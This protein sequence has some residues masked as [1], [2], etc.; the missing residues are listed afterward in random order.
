[1]K[2]LLVDNSL[3]NTGASKALI[4]TVSEIDKQE[5]EFIFLFPKGS[6]CIIAAQA[7]GFRAYEL[8]FNE[9]SKRINSLL[10][11]FPLLFGNTIK[12]KRLIKE[13]GITLVHVNDIYNMLGLSLKLQTGIKVLTHIRRMPESFPLP[14][15]KVW[16]RLHV[17]YADHIIAVSQANKA[18]L[19]AN[20]KTTV[21]YDPLPQ[22]EQYG[23]YIAKKQLNKQAAILYLANFTDGKGHL[24]ALKLVS[25]FIKE[26]PDWQLS[27]HLYGGNF[28]LEKNASYKQSLIQF[29]KDEGLESYVRF[30]GQ[31]HDVE[32]VMKQHDIILNLSDSESFS[33]VTL[34]ALYFGVPIVAT[35][36]GGTNE[37]VLDRQTGILVNRSDI[38]S[39]YHG[40]VNLI[41]DDNLRQMLSKN[42]YSYVRE[43]FGNK[44]TVEKLASVYRLLK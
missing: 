33:R 11:Y 9:I 40:F 32:N 13:E 12:A 37:M 1:M 44:E 31:V 36:V 6:N 42:S 43:K 30:H 20:N 19:P 8:K 2:I 41:L 3:D 17:A 25:R 34:E 21:I 14:I 28:G 18:A 38:D 23:P 39:M 22:D 7:A 29:V 10:L 16:S 26:N 24:H 35:D 5:F 15:Y 4:K 27:L